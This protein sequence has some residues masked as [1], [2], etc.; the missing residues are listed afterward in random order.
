MT[1]MLALVMALAAAASG[2]SD[3]KAPVTPTPVPATLTDTFTGTLA[4][5]GSNTHPFVV[6]QIGAIKVTVDSVSP[7]AAIGIGVGTPSG[8]NC[9]LLQN[10]TA[11]AGP[12]TQISGTATISGTF[13]VSVYDVGNLV[14]SVNYTVTVNHS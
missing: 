2:C 12:N 9:L 1:R 6:T 3:P 13:C 4:V 8:A 5:L 7:G 14:E 11:V 10:I